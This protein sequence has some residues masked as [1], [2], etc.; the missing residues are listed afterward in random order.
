VDF[1]RQKIPDILLLILAGLLVVADFIWN[2]STIPYKLVAGL[3]AYG[4][5]YAVYR[6]RGGLGY[7]D[8]KYAGV[9][10]YFLGPWYIL[11][12]LLFAVLLGLA[13]WSLGRMIFKWGREKRFPFGPWL[14]CGAM[15]AKLLSWWS[16]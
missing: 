10:G 13:Y 12:G 9:I 6:L 7:G 14:G 8:V 5:F 16:A 4:L 2:R 3:G 11:F 1:R 15:A